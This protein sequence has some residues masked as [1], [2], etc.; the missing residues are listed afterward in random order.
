MHLDL[1]QAVAGAGLASS[2][3]DIEGKTARPITPGLGVLG[4]GKE[5]PDIVEEPGVGGRV[6]PGGPPNGGL[7]NGDDLIQKFLSFDPGVLP[8]PGL[9]PVQI[10]GQTLIEDLVDQAGLA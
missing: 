4:G 8:R 9:G 7:V 2:S 10:G 6:G 3:P 5:L 1:D